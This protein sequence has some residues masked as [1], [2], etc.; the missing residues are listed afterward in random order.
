MTVH[1]KGRIFG[2]TLLAISAVSV[3]WIVRMESNQ[4]TSPSKE[5]LAQG[6][7]EKDT[8]YSNPTPAQP[9]P[10]TKPEPTPT[11]V[12]IKVSPPVYTPKPPE[13]EAKE[14]QFVDEPELV[15]ISGSKEVKIP[16]NWVPRTN[17]RSI[18]TSR[19]FQHKEY[20]T[21]RMSKSKQ[22]E[23]YVFPDGSWMKMETKI[24]DGQRSIYLD[25]FK[26]DTK[27]SFRIF[28]SKRRSMGGEQREI[29]VYKIGQGESVIPYSEDAYV[30]SELVK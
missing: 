11:P 4:T 17:D 28:A 19:V 7:I 21:R 13:K 26:K 15:T 9:A 23:M 18:E 27:I 6:V 8:S 22:G 29:L 24:V 14:P 1:I 3:G 12:P 2:C 30:F 5:P 16:P 20:T 25:S 10:E